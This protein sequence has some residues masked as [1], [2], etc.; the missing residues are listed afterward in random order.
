MKKVRY[1]RG[2]SWSDFKRQMYTPEEVI[3]SKK[4]REI[5]EKLYVENHSDFFKDTMLSLF[6]A[7]EIKLGRS[8]TET[9]IQKIIEESSL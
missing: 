4:R 6:E 3:E 8:L 7:A 9:E 5:V 2:T 1:Y